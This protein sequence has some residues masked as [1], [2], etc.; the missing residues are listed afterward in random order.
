[1]QESRK[2]FL[3]LQKA[4]NIMKINIIYA[5]WFR[6]GEKVVEELAETESQR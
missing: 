5:S 1:M 3:N 4:N 6:K 2:K